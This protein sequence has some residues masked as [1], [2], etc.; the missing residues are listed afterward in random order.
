MDALWWWAVALFKVPLHE[1]PVMTIDT[2]FPYYRRLGLALFKLLSFRL[3]TAPNQFLW[4]HFTCS[5]TSIPIS[6][7]Q[8]RHRDLYQKTVNTWNPSAY[9]LGLSEYSQ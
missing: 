4:I 7:K 5:P 9:F 8:H 1:I 3:S 2:F 6:H